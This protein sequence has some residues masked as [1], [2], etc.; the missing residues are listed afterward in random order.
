MLWTCLLVFR[1]S[2]WKNDRLLWPVLRALQRRRDFLQRADTEQQE[3]A[4]SNEGKHQ[5]GLVP[6]NVQ[7]NY[8]T[9]TF[10]Q[11]PMLL[12]PQN[13]AVTFSL[14][15]CSL[16]K[17][18]KDRNERQNK[19]LRVWQKI[20]QQ[21]L[22]RRLGIPECFLL[23]TQRITKYPILVERIIQ[24][25]EGKTSWSVATWS[26]PSPSQRCEG[27]RW[28]LSLACWTCSCNLELFCLIRKDG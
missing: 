24:N 14:R 4:N 7:Q 26:P 13:K 15:W 22:V 25:T 12:T 6:M 21:P 20:A 9:G 27:R 28:R 5:S 23:V 3:T 18:E 1:C 8:Q 19:P 17:E 2:R 16:C 11:G 10:G